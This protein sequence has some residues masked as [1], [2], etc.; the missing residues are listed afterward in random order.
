MDMFLKSYCR[1]GQQAS[2]ACLR[3][4]IILMIPAL[5]LGGCSRTTQDELAF[6]EEPADKLYNEAL[7]LMNK[8]KYSKAA[9]KFNEIDKQHPYSKWAKK[10]MVMATFSYYKGGKFDDAI[11]AG[12]RYVALHPG[13]EEAPYAQYLVAQA[14]FNQVPDISRDQERTRKALAALDEL[15]RRYPESEYIDD[16]KAKR[17]MVRDQLAGRQML[18]G[19]YYLERRDYTGAINRFRIVVSDYQKTRHVEE[20]LM[21]L[22]ESYMAMGVVS[23]AQTAAAVLGHNFPDSRWYKDTYSLLESGGVEPRENT[24]SWISRAFRKVGSLG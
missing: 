10:G 2:A 3:I 24:G 8:G 17:R 16:A 12:K 11:L 13:S 23:E 7:A 15:L 19:R 1:Y 9:E 6:S 5:I 14:Y 22:A 18:I 20:A 21:R 4:L